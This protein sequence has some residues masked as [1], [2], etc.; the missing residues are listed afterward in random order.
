MIAAS[1]SASVSVVTPVTGPPGDRGTRSLRTSRHEPSPLSTHAGGF[2]FTAF[3]VAA[4]QGRFDTARVTPV[5]SSVVTAI[6]NH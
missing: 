3:A 5:S 4:R 1:V 2:V 6:V